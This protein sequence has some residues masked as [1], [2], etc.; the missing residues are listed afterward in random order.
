MSFPFLSFRPDGIISHLSAGIQIRGA[1]YSSRPIPQLKQARLKLSDASPFSASVKLSFPVS[2]LDTHSFFSAS[3][4]LTVQLA[5]SRLWL[6]IQFSGPTVSSRI[7]ISHRASLYNN[8]VTPLLFTVATRQSI[9][10]ALNVLNVSI[11]AHLPDLYVLIYHDFGPINNLSHFDCRL[12]RCFIRFR[13]LVLQIFLRYLPDIR[14][15]D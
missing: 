12:Y 2:S 10:S 15:V 14:H 7:F 5:F 13:I 1:V 4:M 8:K 3:Q 9:S 11:P 6:R